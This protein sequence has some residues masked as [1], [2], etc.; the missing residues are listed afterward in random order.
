MASA[1]DK[2]IHILDK[3]ATINSKGYREL[4]SDDEPMGC[5]NGT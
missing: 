1:L 5:C 2:Y 4:N 3:Y